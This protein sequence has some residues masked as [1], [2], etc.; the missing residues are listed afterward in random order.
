M[1]VTGKQFNKQGAAGG[2]LVYWECIELGMVEIPH[3]IS[4][5]DIMIKIDMTNNKT[6]AA[7]P[8]FYLSDFI[9]VPVDE[10]VARCDAS[11]KSISPG[12]T[13]EEE[14]LV[15][16]SIASPK[17]VS[18]IYVYN[19]TDAKLIQSW[20]NI[21]G[22]TIVLENNKSQRIWLFTTT[23]YYVYHPVIVKPTILELSAE[24]NPRY[25]SMRGNR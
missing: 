3:T 20:Q 6:A 23:P 19:T 15:V 1:S 11:D 21:P 12:L 10:F 25:L 14:E 2:T 7:F 8:D 24:V 9:L 5:Q 18:S 4:P 16:T 13:V 17:D 22:S